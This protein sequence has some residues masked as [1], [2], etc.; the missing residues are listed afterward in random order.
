[1]MPPGV[2]WTHPDHRKAFLPSFLR[3]FDDGPFS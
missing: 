1:M 3:P 2:F